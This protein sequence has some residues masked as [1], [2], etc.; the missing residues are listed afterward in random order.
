L[1]GGKM[2]A[3]D[4]DRLVY[5]IKQ[6]ALSLRKQELEMIVSRYN[7]L[8]GLCSIM[9]GF[10]FDA[11]VEL[12]FPER[13]EDGTIPHDHILQMLKPIFYLACSL[14]LSLSL[15]VVAVASFTVVY[16]HQLALLG[17]HANSLDKAVAVMLK[18]HNPL[19]VTSSSA[20]ICVVIAATTIAWIKM[21]PPFAMTATIIFGV[22]MAAT[23]LALRRLNIQLSKSYL[24]H[25]DMHVL[26]NGGSGQVDLTRLYAIGGEVQVKRDT[27]YGGIGSEERRSV[28]GALRRLQ[29]WMPWS[30][31]GDASSN[32]A[33]PKAG[34]QG[35]D[36]TIHAKSGGWRENAECQDGGNPRDLAA[37]KPSMLHQH[38]TRDAA[39]CYEMDPSAPISPI[40][41]A[42][43]TMYSNIASS[44][45]STPRDIR[46]ADL[47]LDPT[48][49]SKAKSVVFTK[50][51]R[52]PAA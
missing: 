43:S 21:D 11:I 15:Y 14:S 47:D 7:N 26:G 28:L 17:A 33:Y 46:A 12:E 24:I 40:D 16:G 27:T 39:N 41:T 37:Q 38:F 19:F 22:M 6:K 48:G 30:W 8:A 45:H 10:S 42:A 52:T 35:G 25:G 20:M 50:Q 51:M 2:L 34:R 23:M 49:Q 1:S 29:A 31:G 9:A 5:E 4:K 3:A 13:F 32:G 18:Q 44:A 36:S